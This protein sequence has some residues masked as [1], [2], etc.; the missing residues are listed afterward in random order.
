M[1]DVQLTDNVVVWGAAIAAKGVWM[2]RYA[3]E[4]KTLLHA[5]STSTIYQALTGELPIPDS[6]F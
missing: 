1:Y 6:S 5:R 3:L 2:V 4:K